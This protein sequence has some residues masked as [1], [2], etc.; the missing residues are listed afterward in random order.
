MGSASRAASVTSPPAAAATRAARATRWR[1]VP[2]P[3]WSRYFW[4]VDAARGQPRV[5]EAV[6]QATSPQGGLEHGQGEQLLDHVGRG[7]VGQLRHAP[8]LGHQRLGPVA[9]GQLLPLVVAGPRHAEGPARL[10]H[11]PASGG[12]LQHGQTTVIDDVCWGHGDGLHGSVEGTT[13]SI[14]GPHPV[15]DLQPQPRSGRS[16]EALWI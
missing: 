2:R 7:G 8:G 4:A 9:V 15:V 16:R 3:A 13:E 11:V 14:A 12:V 6:G 10:A 5:G 1:R